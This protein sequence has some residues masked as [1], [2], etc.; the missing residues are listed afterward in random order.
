MPVQ[1]NT[2]LVEFKGGL[3]S[4]LSPLQQGINAVGSATILQNFEPSLSGGYRK[5]AGYEKF[6]DAEVTGTGTIQGVAVVPG[7][8]SNQV[9]VI[10]DGVYY[11]GAGGSYTSK[12]TA[13]TTTASKVR[14]ARYNF[15]GTEKIVF[16]DSNNYPAYYDTDAETVT[17]LSS[18]T[19]NDEVQ[20]AEH[21]AFFKNALFLSKG[22]NVFFTAPFTD[23]DLEPASGGGVI[24]VG[25]DVTGMIVFREQ[26][27]IFSRDRITRLA[28]TTVSD[29]A[30]QPITEDIGCIQEDTIQEIGGD[31]IF[32]GPDGLR[33]LSATERIGDFGLDVASKPIKTNYESFKDNSSTF[34]S[35]VLR[36]KAQY[37]IFGYSPTNRASVSRGLLATKFV[38]QGGTGLNWAELRGFKVFA[39]DSFIVGDSEFVVFTNDDGYVYRMEFGASRDGENID[40][41]YE[42]P[43]MPI[44]D[45]QMRKTYYKLALYMEPT[46]LLG[47][48]ASIR[49]DQNAPDVIQPPTIVVETEG[50]NVFL[51][52]EPDAVFGTATFG[53]ELNK[54]YNRN[55]IGSGKTVAIRIEDISTNPSFTL[56]TAV[57][58]YADN[59]RQ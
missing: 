38:D 48:T 52:G 34:S 56:D 14:F 55:V 9:I 44:N 36:N 59:D 29:Y 20:G 54:L 21:V 31:V 40:A 4:N 50:S 39:C 33:T 43:F 25:S 37:R 41:I 45:P 12:A 8:G 53:G 58:E 46:G 10:R 47:F 3:V 17:F 1:W 51:Y 27:I 15:S 49:L 22:S 5:V 24:N 23:D 16:V 6:I 42:S 13:S 35:L 19:V 28:G 32:M 57:L 2:W 7:T 18:S 26:L 30:L 11:L